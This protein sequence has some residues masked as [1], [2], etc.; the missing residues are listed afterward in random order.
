M[1]T[2]ATAKAGLTRHKRPQSWGITTTYRHAPFH[3]QNPSSQRWKSWPFRDSN[4]TFSSLTRFRKH[5]SIAGILNRLCD[6][7][8]SERLSTADSSVSSHTL[9]FSLHRYSLHSSPQQT[10]IRTRVDVFST[11]PWNL[12][13]EILKPR[14]DEIDSFD[15]FFRLVTQLGTC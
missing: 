9:D 6:N 2:H 15:V 4:L 10:K 7:N 1:I 8:L 14:N 3:P 13:H 12:N 5:F 11:F